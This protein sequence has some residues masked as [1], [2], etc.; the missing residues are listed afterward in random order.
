VPGDLAPEEDARLDELA[1]A[2]GLRVTRGGRFHHLIG[3]ASKG[4]A[5]RL[6]L[7]AY[8]TGAG[9]VRSLGLGDGPN[10]LELL[11][12]V[13]RPVVVARPDRSHDPELQQAL[14]HARFTP[15]IG[16]EGFREAILDYLV[17]PW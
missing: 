16:P 7:S 14:P 11:Q 4:A 2:L 6:L 13:D 12:V 3:P 15:G 10:D 1:D 9:P 8:D 5:A 17:E